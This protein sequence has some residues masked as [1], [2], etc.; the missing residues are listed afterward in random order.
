MK[1]KCTYV[2]KSRWIEVARAC[3]YATYF[4][5]PYWY[6]L[7][8]PGQRH[9]A[10]EVSFDDGASAVIPIAKIKRACGLLT[11]HF[12]SPGGTYGGWISASGLNKDHVRVLTNI[13]TAKKNLTFRLNP[14]DHSQSSLL[15]VSMPV[16][17]SSM[18]L[19]NDV[20]YTLDLTLGE[21]ELHGRSNRGHKEKLR[22]AARNAITV[23]EARGWEE[24]ERYYDLYRQSVD[25][26]TA[27]GPEL[28]P[29]VVY[30]IDLF[31]RLHN[32]VSG[33]ERFWVALKDG[34]VIGGM[35]CFYWN[36]HAVGW[37]ASADSRYFSLGSNNRLY[38]E[39]ILDAMRGGFEIFDCNPSGGYG[40]VETFKEHLG[41]KRVSS[42]VLSART[43]LRS[44]LTR[45][46]PR[47]SSPS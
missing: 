41:A 24:W 20:T 1:Y 21:R 14:F 43:P 15:T 27:R 9:R 8:A 22:K 46:R 17:S 29:R 36:R 6:E 28:T 47:P 4:H 11:D 19:M 37:H 12:S 26:W 33:C 13:L 3:P 38:W 10:V 34:E 5:T 31:R 23:R 7:I 44:L 40:G 45:L 2:S 30:P 25:R 35:L 16:P 32:S 42:P 39:I 18:R